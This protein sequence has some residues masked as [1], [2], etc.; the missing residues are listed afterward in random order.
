M[1]NDETIGSRHRYRRQAL[2]RESRQL[3]KIWTAIP[4]ISISN[5]LIEAAQRVQFHCSAYLLKGVEMTNETIK[6]LLMVMLLGGL[7]T[8][9]FVTTEMPKSQPWL[10][11]P[12]AFLD[13]VIVGPASNAS[14]S[15]IAI[16]GRA[17]SR[18]MEAA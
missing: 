11:H 18:D 2:A 10:V 7:R 13:W 9:I 5:Y 4:T 14:A 17:S 15:A 16:R 1:T 3:R 8:A 6:A 12:Q